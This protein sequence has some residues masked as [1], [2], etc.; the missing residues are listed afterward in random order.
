MSQL[1]P[2][3]TCAHLINMEIPNITIEDMFKMQ[4]S[5]Q[6]HLASKGKG[7]NIDTLS[8]SQMI[9]GLIY[10]F[11]NVTLEYAELMERLPHKTW[12]TYTAEQLNGFIDEKHKFEVLYEYMDMFIF[13]MNMG[14]MLGIDGELFKKLYYTKNLENFNR[15]NNGY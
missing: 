11:H 3:N 5:L 12:K 7:P 13:L 6:D 2:E 1:N 10:N 14:L 9:D 4:K 15:Q 8:Y